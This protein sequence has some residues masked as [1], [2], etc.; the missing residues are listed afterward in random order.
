MTV[1]AVGDARCSLVM[2]QTLL[3][4]YS[5]DAAAQARIESA[6]TLPGFSDLIASKSP[7]THSTRTNGPKASLLPNEA[8]VL[9]NETAVE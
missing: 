8:A 1:L 9:S 6:W 4:A 3:G 2:M 7:C 5:S